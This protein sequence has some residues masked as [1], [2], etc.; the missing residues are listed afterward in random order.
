MIEIFYTGKDWN[1]KD[2]Y[3]SKSKLTEN[4]LLQEINDS[5]RLDKLYRSKCSYLCF[6]QYPKEI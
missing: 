3:R 2:A 6:S 5:F 4:E 1:Y